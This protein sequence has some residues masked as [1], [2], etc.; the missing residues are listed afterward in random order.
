MQNKSDAV[1]LFRLRTSGSIASGDLK[2]GLGRYGVI[3]AFGRKEVENFSF[4]PSLTG[5]YNENI[6]VE[7][8]LDGFNDQNVAVKANVR[9]APTFTVEPP[10]IDFGSVDTTSN[11]PLEKMGFTLTNV[12]K[13]E[14]T[15][16]VEIKSPSPAQE[17]DDRDRFVD[18][19]LS[20]DEV[21]QAL[22]KTEEEEIENILQKLKIA[23][24]KGKKDKISKYKARLAE[25]GVQAP[26][27]GHADASDVEDGAADEAVSE[28]P[29]SAATANTDAEGAAPSTSSAGAAVNDGPRSVPDSQDPPSGSQTPAV[30]VDAPEYGP[31][32]RVSILTVVLQPNQKNRILVEL[33]PRSPLSSSSSPSASLPSSNNPLSNTSLEAVLQVHDKKNADESQA[34][35]VVA[36]R[37]AGSATGTNMSINGGAADA[38]TGNTNNDTSSSQPTAALPLSEGERRVCDALPR[39]GSKH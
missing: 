38:S 39:H 30:E 34:V 9:K 6:V 23:K 5:T 12:S 2:L 21:G 25:L 32:H 31:K 11:T 17:G 37:S 13:H 19:S 29:T 15:F 35:K 27:E 18:L 16:V 36:R 8:V 1:G 7:N 26:A 28:A 3:S 24:R 22:S 33:I 10:L 4:T 20:R 14:R